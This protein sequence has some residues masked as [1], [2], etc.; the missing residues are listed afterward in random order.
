[1]A[2][3]RWDPARDIEAFQSDMNRMFDS[4]F[5]SDGNSSVRRWAPAADVTESGDDLVLQMD[6]PGL[7]EDAVTVEVEDGVLTVSG[8][9]KDE[10][11]HESEGIHRLERTYGKFARSFNLPAGTDPDSISG[12]FENGVLELRIPKPAEKKPRRVAIGSGAGAGTIEGTSAESQ[13]DR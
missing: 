13:A 1:M 9:R 6:L 8:E 4:F 3:V 7:T 12:D 5:R 10:R 2:I 11:R